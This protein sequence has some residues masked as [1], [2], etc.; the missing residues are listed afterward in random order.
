MA[1]RLPPTKRPKISAYHDIIPLFNDSYNIIHSSEASIR[2][3][4]PTLRSTRRGNSPELIAGVWES[5]TAWSPPDD[6]ELALDQDGSSYQELVDGPV[7]ESGPQA[8][9]P[10]KKKRSVV[11]VSLF[12]FCS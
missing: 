5:I 7:M 1:S 3:S 4:G 2:G 9:P 10:K 6:R 12:Y 11:S 8:L